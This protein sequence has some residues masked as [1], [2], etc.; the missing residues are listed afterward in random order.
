MNQEEL[1]PFICYPIDVDGAADRD[2]IGGIHGRL[3][4]TNGRD[5]HCG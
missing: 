5:S 1:N 2:G 4:G 3:V